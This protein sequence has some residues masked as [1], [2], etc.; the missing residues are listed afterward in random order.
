MIPK[1]ISIDKHYS[2]AGVTVIGVHSPKYEHEKH[3]SNIRHAIEEQSLPF[4]VVND[5]SLQVWKHT[6]C[7]IRPTVLVFGPDA[8]PIFIFEGENH[9][10]HTEVFLLR[11]LA[12]YKSSVRASPSGSS[13]MKTSPEDIAAATSSKNVLWRNEE[14][15]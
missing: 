7:Q 9:V 11:V 4:N 12:Y 5:N 1:L 15:L 14:R 13:V 2:T 8:L 6:N 3:K 10:Q